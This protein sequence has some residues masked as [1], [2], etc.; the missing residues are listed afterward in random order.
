MRIDEREID[1]RTGPLIDDAVAAM[2]A[3]GIA[4]TDI[5]HALISTGLAYF[6]GRMCA[7]HVLE[8]LAF[9]KQ[10]MEDKTTE[11]RKECS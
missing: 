11:L 9:V 10:F 6:R 5:G 3:Q 2:E 4:A 1:D 8:Q 7:E